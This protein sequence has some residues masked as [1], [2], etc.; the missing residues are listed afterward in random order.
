[1]AVKGKI[2]TS[3]NAAS[4]S[5]FA[6]SISYAFLEWDKRSD[7]MVNLLPH[8]MRT[9]ND[10]VPMRLY[11]ESS[12]CVRCLSHGTPI[13]G[14]NTR[15]NVLVSRNLMSTPQ[16]LFNSVICG[17]LY[18]VFLD[19]SWLNRS[20]SKQLSFHHQLIRRNLMHHDHSTAITLEPWCSFLFFVLIDP[21]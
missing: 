9:L 11:L 14:E 4:P 12:H 17:H 8:L 7:E 16:S 5:C 3:Y 19:S 2:I 18:N 1:M 6:I 15:P 10:L 13:S 20:C 21:Q